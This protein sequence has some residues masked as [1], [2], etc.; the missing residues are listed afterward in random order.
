MGIRAAF[1]DMRYAF[2]KSAANF[3]QHWRATAIFNPIVQQRRDCEI[4][5][6]AS[7]ENNSGNDQ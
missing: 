5:I 2:A 7:F 3:F 6:A 1:D 4:F